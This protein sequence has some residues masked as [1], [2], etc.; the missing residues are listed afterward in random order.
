MNVGKL[1]PMLL[2]VHVKTD[3]S[4]FNSRKLTGEALAPR[5]RHLGLHFHPLTDITLEMFQR[6]QAPV[7]SGRGH[8]E[9]ETA[10]DGI[11]NIEQGTDLLA[12]LGTIFQANPAGLVDINPQNS[13]TAALEFNVNELKA[14]P[15]NH[16]FQKRYQIFLTH[17]HKTKMGPRPI[18]INLRLGA[19]PY[20]APNGLRPKNNKAPCGALMPKT[21]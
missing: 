6:A 7:Q 5:H 8:L 12:G 4:A 10:R 15:V 17:L 21:W 19:R 13:Y 9:R 16:W 20:D 18:L 2:S 3:L 14:E 1:D 11:L